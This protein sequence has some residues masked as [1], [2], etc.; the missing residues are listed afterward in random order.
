MD[1]KI[2]SDEIERQENNYGIE[3]LIKA[4]ERDL[5]EDL[6][7]K[8]R[9]TFSMGR[10]CWH[11]NEKCVDKMRQYEKTGVLCENECEY[12]N[13][14]KWVIDRAKHYAEKTGLSVDEVLESWE[15]DRSYW[16]LNYYQ[17]CNQP[18]LKDGTK[19]FASIDE[20]RKS[21]GD[22]GFRC[23]MC[24]GVSTDP[25]KCNSGLPMKSGK[26][27]DWTTYGLFLSGVSVYFV[28]ERKNARIFKPI[29][30]EVE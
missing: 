14:F 25:C 17:E 28:K 30:W 15:E 7:R 23:T 27:C 20:W 8:Q 13:K 6:E 11:Y 9:G 1:E 21:V 4:I 2:L 26:N 24:G 16:F 10:G 12:C 19:V 22:K 18:E 3:T 29:A 5:K